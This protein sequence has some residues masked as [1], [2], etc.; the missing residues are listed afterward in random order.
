MFVGRIWF[1]WV[2]LQFLAIGAPE[3]GGVVVYVQADSA[4]RLDVGMAE[5]IYD[6]TDC[7]QIAFW[8]GCG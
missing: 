4:F 7:D 5:G 8:C 2:S 1:L 3:K 6:P